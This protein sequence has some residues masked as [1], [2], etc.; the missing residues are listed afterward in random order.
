MQFEKHLLL[1]AAEEVRILAP[2]PNGR[3]GGWVDRFLRLPW[4]DMSEG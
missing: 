1:Q 4:P 2:R 3:S